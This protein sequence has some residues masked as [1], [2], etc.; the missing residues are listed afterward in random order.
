MKNREN[1]DILGDMPDVEVFDLAE[2]ME[3]IDS[4]GGKVKCY[5]MENGKDG[6][7]F[8][9]EESSGY[10][11][12][13]LMERLRDDYGGGEYVAKLFAGERNRL[14]RVS[15]FRIIEAKSRSSLYEP[16]RE[17]ELHSAGEPDKFM[18][19]LLQQHQASQAQLTTIL[20]A[21]LGQQRGK[22]DGLGVADVLSLVDRMVSSK[23]GGADIAGV[24]DVLTAG[25]SLGKE[26]SG[27]APDRGG[28]M[29]ILAGL[30]PVLAAQAAQQ[31]APAALP[32][33]AVAQDSDA[34]EPPPAPVRR[35]PPP[36]ER[37]QANTG[38]VP[39][40]ATVLMQ[41]A[42]KN[43]DPEPYAAI[44]GDFMTEEQL[45]VV[46]GDES[47]FWSVVQQI[48]GSD[49]FR[50][51]FSLLYAA[52]QDLYSEQDSGNDD[53]GDQLPASE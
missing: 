29:D 24:M 20:T 15:R 39:P 3:E 41:A 4:G 22:S 13:D 9:I 40:W 42:K 31:A 48:P 38:V 6:W 19:F 12:S 28:F 7:L 37:Q 44:L 51:W 26:A 53:A 46:L 14:K 5:K 35:Q 10:T 8:D 16:H 21:V 30:V 49:G 11:A 27:N 33:P 18:Q 36:A 52:L 25:I 2:F 47:L 43:A 34:N 32:A 23:S 45:A 50:A 17:K 1:E